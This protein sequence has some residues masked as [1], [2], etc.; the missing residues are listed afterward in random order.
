MDKPHV[1][2]KGVTINW[3]Q[4]D[5]IATHIRN[6]KTVFYDPLKQQYVIDGMIIDASFLNECISK[7]S[8]FINTL[9]NVQLSKKIIVN[10]DSLVEQSMTNAVRTKEYE[11]K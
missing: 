3:T 11:E 10:I 4:M 6:A 9:S 8:H 5:T 7:T 1:T 2:N